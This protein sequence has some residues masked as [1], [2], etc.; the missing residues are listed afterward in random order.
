M[1]IYNAEI[2]KLTKKINIV[3]SMIFV[4]MITGFSAC[5]NALDTAPL[6]AASAARFYVDEE[7]AKQVLIGVYRGANGVDGNGFTTYK[8]SF[9]MDLASDNA[10]NVLGLNTDYCNLVNGALSPSNPIVSNFWAGGYNK[11]M[12]A[13]DFLGNL[14]KMSP[15]EISDAS[16]KRFK[17]EARFLRAIEYFYLNQFYGSVP[18]VTTLLSAQEANSV[19]KA[20]N[21]QLQE[22]ITTELLAASADLPSFATITGLDR[23]RASKQA[24]LAYLGRLKLAQKKFDEAA[25]VYKQIIDAGEN[26]IASNYENVFTTDKFSNENIYSL[27]FISGA[28]YAANSTPLP[29]QCLPAVNGGQVGINPTEDLATS[30]DFTDGTP[31]SYS[32]PRYNPNNLAANR[33]PRF[34][35]TILYNGAVLGGKPYVSDPDAVASK[36]RTTASGVLQA[37]KT[38]Y[39][40]RKYLPANG[41]LV[42]NY[43]GNIPL[44]RYSEV[45]LSYL[46]AMLEGSG[47]IDQALLNNTINKVRGRAG[48]NM[49]AITVTDKTALRPIL[50]KERRVELA[51]EGVRLWDLKRWNLLSTLS[52]KVAWG[53]PFPSSTGNLN[54]AQNLPNPQKLWYIGKWNFQAG[55][56]IWPIPETE[57]AINPNLR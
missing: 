28:S 41:V 16:K 26:Q 51:L 55:Q 37:T 3:A 40:M 2:M 33:D 39:C 46:E 21:E 11:I 6:N 54:N 8:G 56:E 36:D 29:A 30:Y 48:V 15:A 27:Q 24:A 22:F 52:N 47:T 53:A 13:N 34:A 50:R 5:K 23:G 4:L 31:F 49:P 57:Q 1:L 14:E 42:N 35:Y 9:W 18:L 38:G 20:T 25:A 19:S 7:S 45:L 17:A 44:I 12:L 10:V 32:D 43:G